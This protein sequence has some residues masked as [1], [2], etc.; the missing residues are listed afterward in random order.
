MSILCSVQCDR[1]S[2]CSEDDVGHA[3]AAATHFALWMI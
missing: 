3:M 2:D 1:R